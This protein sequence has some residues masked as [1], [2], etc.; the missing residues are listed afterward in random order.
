MTL[1]QML[2]PTFHH[3]FPGKKMILLLDNAPYHRCQGPEGESSIKSS[4]RSELIDWVVEKCEEQ[5]IESVNWDRNLILVP[6]TV[7]FYTF[8]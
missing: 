8:T 7:S 1:S 6:V 2:I 3:L 5:E 4:K